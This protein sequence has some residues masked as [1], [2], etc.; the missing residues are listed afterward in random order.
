MASLFCRS[1]ATLQLKSL[2]RLTLYTR[3]TL[4][5]LVKTHV[6]NIY[7]CANQDILLFRLRRT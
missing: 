7:R 3:Y 2:A 6:H 4:L 5:Y 1:A